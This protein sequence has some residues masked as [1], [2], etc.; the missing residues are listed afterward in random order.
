M[1]TAQGLTLREALPSLFFT[2]FAAFSN[3]TL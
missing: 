3:A 1:A 2:R